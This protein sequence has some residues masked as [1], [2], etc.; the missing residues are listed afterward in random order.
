MIFNA[1]PVNILRIILTYQNNMIE[2]FIVILWLI[3]VNKRFD[4][5]FKLISL[6]ITQRANTN[7]NKY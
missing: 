4:K 1:L 6:F 2:A 3:L 7:K 5:Y